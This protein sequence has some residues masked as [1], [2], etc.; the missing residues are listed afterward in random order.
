MCFCGPLHVSVYT[1][2][3][4]PRM[5]AWKSTYLHSLPTHI[6]LSRIISVEAF[7]MITFVFLFSFLSLFPF[8][9]LLF[10][11]YCITII[12]DLIFDITL[13]DILYYLF[14]TQQTIM[15]LSN[16]RN[17]NSLESDEEKKGISLSDHDDK[18][19]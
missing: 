19:T 5:N 12:Y 3:R 17:I 15:P 7:G 2:V 10:M 11:I 6:Y 16:K 4:E 18:P 13:C 8:A 1:C 14:I 9:K